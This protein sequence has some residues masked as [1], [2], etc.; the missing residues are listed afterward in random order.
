MSLNIL[1]HV[2]LAYQPIWGAK[3]QLAAVRL[4]VRA[5]HP[6]S[7]DAAHLLQLLSSERQPHTP[8][9][10]VSFVDRALLLQALSVSPQEGIWLELPDEGDF[11]TD[12]L[13]QHIQ[14]ARR[15]GHQLVQCGPLARA[16]QG[17]GAG[18][19]RFV[20]SD[21]TPRDIPLVIR[22]IHCRR[23]VNHAVFEGEVFGLEGLKKRIDHRVFSYFGSIK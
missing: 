20:S 2:G 10:L 23:C 22:H 1:D 19:Q 17:V 8:P 7:V 3:R 15:M 21:R 4:R 5:F 11:A 6:E 12:E 18:R 9:L 13:R 16:A 14:F